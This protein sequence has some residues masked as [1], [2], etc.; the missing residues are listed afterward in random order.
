MYVG[1]WIRSC[2]HRI[3]TCFVSRVFRVD[4]GMYVGMRIRVGSSSAGFH[5]HLVPWSQKSGGALQQHHAF[6][7]VGAAQPAVGAG[8]VRSLRTQTTASALG[9]SGSRAK[10]DNGGNA[11][12]HLQGLP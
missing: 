8:Q 12:Q 2:A 9:H 5:A 11:S 3:V 7:L 4:N 1:M 10:D 6:P